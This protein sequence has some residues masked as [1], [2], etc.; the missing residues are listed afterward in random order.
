VTLSAACG[1]RPSCNYIIDYRL[2]GDPAHACGKDYVVEYRCDSTSSPSTVTIKAEAG[3][4]SALNLACPG[5]RPPPLVVPNRPPP[6][7]PSMGGPRLPTVGG[8]QH[9]P[10]GPHGRPNRQQ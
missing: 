1:G 6:R 9:P 4:G 7:L 8:Q 10:L 5:A 2:I 3:L